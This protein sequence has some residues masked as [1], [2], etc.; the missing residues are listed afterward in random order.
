MGNILFDKI[1]K[2]SCF[3]RCARYFRKLPLNERDACYWSF[4]TR[5]TSSLFAIKIFRHRYCWASWDCY[6][7][8]PLDDYAP[9]VEHNDDPIFSESL[10][11]SAVMF[12]CSLVTWAGFGRRRGLLIELDFGRNSLLDF[13]LLLFNRIQG[14]PFC[15]LVA[16]PLL[17]YFAQCWRERIIGSMPFLRVL[18]PC[19]MKTV[20]SRI[21]TSIPV[22]IFY[23]NN[24]LHFDCQ[25]F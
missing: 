19:K 2:H 3:F 11:V 5:I 20:S 17:D 25:T 15:M 18:V 7:N 8:M 1:N 13:I 14:F 12:S 21:W 16:I 4:V 6:K 9:S 22:S 24:H 23:V 10:L